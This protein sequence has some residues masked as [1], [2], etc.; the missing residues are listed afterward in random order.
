MIK[1]IYKLKTPE[2]VI[3]TRA[4]LDG[5]EWCWEF[6]HYVLT[7]AGLVE[8]SY[9][10]KGYGFVSFGIKVARDFDQEAAAMHLLERDDEFDMYDI[11]ES[12]NY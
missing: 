5:S 4:V 3:V 6:K 8:A 7:T 2:H 11:S 9:E 10:P 1:S 12:L